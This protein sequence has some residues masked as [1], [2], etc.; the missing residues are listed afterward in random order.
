MAYGLPASDWGNKVGLRSK[1]SVTS[2]DQFVTAIEEVEFA[3]P[4]YCHG[5]TGKTH[6]ACRDACRLHIWR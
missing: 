1:G 2:C 5:G 6:E 4:R 3:V